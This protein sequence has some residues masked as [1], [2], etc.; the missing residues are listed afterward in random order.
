MTHNYITN[1]DYELSM[2]SRAAHFGNT[3]VEYAFFT[4]SIAWNFN[5]IEEDGS[6]K[7]SLQSSSVKGKA[8]MMSALDKYQEATEYLNSVGIPCVDAAKR[9]VEAGVSIFGDLKTATLG[10]GKGGATFTNEGS[11]WND[12]GGKIMAKAVIPII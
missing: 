6:L 1:T 11:H 10:S 8:K 3:D 7:H 9:W 4:A 12:T 5:G 2:F